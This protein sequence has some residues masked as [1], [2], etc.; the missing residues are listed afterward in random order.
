MLSHVVA[1][2][3]LLCFTMIP[4]PKDKRESKSESNQYQQRAIA[5]SIIFVKLCDSINIK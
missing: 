5:E 1:P 3:D 2:F 4:V